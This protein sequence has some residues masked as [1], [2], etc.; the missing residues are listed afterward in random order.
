[1][2]SINPTGFLLPTVSFIILF[3]AFFLASQILLMLIGSN[4]VCN[5]S[6]LPSSLL[7]HLRSFV[8]I[9]DR[10]S[11][12]NSIYNEQLAIPKHFGRGHKTELSSS[13]SADG[14]NF[15][16]AGTTFISDSKS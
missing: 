9:S 2:S 13:S 1:M 11:P 10:L 14:K 12:E 6:Y 15:N 16:I 4:A 8:S 7:W 3:R 5:I